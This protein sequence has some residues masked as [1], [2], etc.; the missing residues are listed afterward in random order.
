MTRPVWRATRLNA[1]Y[2][3][4]LRLAE[5]VL[6]ATSVE[7]LRGTVAAN[8]LL[9]SM[10]RLFEDFVTAAL[11]ERLTA[12]R[13]RVVAQDTARSLDRDG[14][15]P[16]RPDLVWYDGV[17]PLAVVDAKYKAEK[18][19]GFPG[20]DVYQLLAYCT[21]Y[22]LRRGHLVYAAGNDAP[23]VYRI[24][25]AGVEVTAHTLD[26]TASPVALLAQVDNLVVTVAEAA[27]NEAK[28]LV[29]GGP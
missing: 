17:R 22:G 15:V 24:T 25:G 21:A 4:A 12:R 13:G 2:V 3:P 26:L 16:L 5:I 18:P 6:D 27:R 29:I 14:H 23:P 10:P 11:G 20:A 19:E 1:H 7:P 28:Q 9:V 8:G